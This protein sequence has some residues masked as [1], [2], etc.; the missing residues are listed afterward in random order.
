MSMG[1]HQP[2]NHESSVQVDELCAIRLVLRGARG[3][4]YVDES[5]VTYGYGIRPGH[6]L[7]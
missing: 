3:I 4:A 6:F 2:G 5:T 1:I 7:I